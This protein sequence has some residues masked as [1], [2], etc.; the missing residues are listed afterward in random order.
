MPCLY[1]V[2][3]Y[4]INKM[5]EIVLVLR[6]TFLYKFTYIHVFESEMFKKIVLIMF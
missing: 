3:I 1:R 4:C 2:K 6:Y 5:L